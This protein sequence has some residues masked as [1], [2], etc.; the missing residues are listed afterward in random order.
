MMN[1]WVGRGNDAVQGLGQGN[2]GVESWWCDSLGKLDGLVFVLGQ[3]P[4]AW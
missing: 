3:I 1:P 4:E 2:D